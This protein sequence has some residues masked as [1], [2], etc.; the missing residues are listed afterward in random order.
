M[1]TRLSICQRKARYPSAAEALAAARASGLVLRSYRCD[2]CFQ[3]HLTSKTKG[4]RVPLW[5]RAPLP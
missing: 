1:R 2:R 3:W 5:E 4:R